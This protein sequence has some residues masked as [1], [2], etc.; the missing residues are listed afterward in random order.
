MRRI[1]KWCNFHTMKILVAKPVIKCLLRVFFPDEDRPI[2]DT[3]THINLRSAIDLSDC[4]YFRQ[5]KSSE[6]IYLKHNSETKK[7]VLSCFDKI[8]T[9]DHTQIRPGIQ[10]TAHILNWNKLNKLILL[11][12]GPIISPPL[13]SPV[14]CQ[15]LYSLTKMLIKIG[16]M[17]NV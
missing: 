8:K 13:D 14:V 16:K 3:F 4:M 17:M 5:G 1:K 15:K 10:K 11:W 9:K 12:P 2:N 7:S 6:Y